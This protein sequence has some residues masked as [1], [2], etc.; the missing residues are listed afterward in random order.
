[1]EESTG[2]VEEGLISV[3]EGMWR[4]SADLIFS[5]RCRYRTKLVDEI[6]DM[7]E[8]SQGLIIEA[9]GHMVH[10]AKYQYGKLDDQGCI[11]VIC[12]EHGAFFIPLIDHLVTPMNVPYPIGCPRCLTAKLMFKTA[13]NFIRKAED[14]HGSRY[15]YRFVLYEH[16]NKPV[17][18]ICS[19]PGHPTFESTADYFLRSIGCS[20]CEEDRRYQFRLDTID[21]VI[22]KAKR[23]FGSKVTYDYEQLYDDEQGRQHIVFKCPICGLVNDQI[24][25]RHIKQRCGCYHCNMQ[26][27][28]DA[29]SCDMK[30]ITDQANALYGKSDFEYLAIT[31]PE[32]G[33]HYNHQISYRC[34]RCGCESTDSV[35]DHL[36]YQKGCRMCDD[37]PRIPIVNTQYPMRLYLARLTLID[38]VAKEKKV[39]ATVGCVRKTVI[40]RLKFDTSLY[41]NLHYSIVDW[42]TVNPS[43]FSYEV[44]QII[45]DKF[46]DHRY[47][48]DI[49]LRSGVTHMF[50]D[51]VTDEIHKFMFSDELINWK[52]EHNTLTLLAG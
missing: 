42:L 41:K 26:R 48:G 29:H 16:D 30:L 33:I 45:L 31:E 52:M 34:L 46:R 35:I 2:I 40:S 22:V 23:I 9:L 6:I 18:I 43:A 13:A 20:R 50:D 47:H 25:Y 5:K 39:F 7:N 36:I 37:S 28:M 14:T 1:M 27:I 8:G 4:A 51:S 12:P 44:E 21:D 19:V 11:E 15:D 17:R 24:T 49:S 38:S 10:G 3:I 32:A